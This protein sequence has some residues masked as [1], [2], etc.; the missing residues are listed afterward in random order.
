MSTTHAVELPSNFFYIVGVV[1][2]RLLLA[3]PAIRLCLR[4]IL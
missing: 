2:Q 3:V 4:C 1:C